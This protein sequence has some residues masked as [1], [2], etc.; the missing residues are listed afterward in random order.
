MPMQHYGAGHRVLVSVFSLSGPATMG[1]FEILRR[2]PVES[3]EPMY[4]LR[5]IREPY[6]RM[7]PENELMQFTPSPAPAPVETALVSI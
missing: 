5:S 1:E 2:Y 4:S 3:G 7:V 6:E